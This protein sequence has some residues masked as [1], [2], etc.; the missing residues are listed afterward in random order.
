MQN[1][2]V[3]KLLVISLPAIAILA[4]IAVVVVVNQVHVLSL[5]RDIAAIAGVHPF[6]GVLS[7]LGILL[8][9]ATASTCAFAAIILRSIE[10]RKNY[11]FLVTSAFL[12]AYLMFD[13]LFQFHECIADRCLGLNEKV[14]YVLLG[15]SVF[16]YLVY[17]R[18][19]ILQTNVITLFLALVFLSLSVSIDAIFESWLA[20]TGHWVYFIEDGAKWI[21]IVFWS[22]YFIE[23]AFQFVARTNMSN[24]ANPTLNLSG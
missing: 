20:W 21:G 6:T 18:K 16:T 24:Q 13:D 8:W 2:S 9:C 17:F 3:K 15:I 19:I 1:T 11:L 7:N 23:T 10:S 5:T 4:A 22:S 12:S 14:I